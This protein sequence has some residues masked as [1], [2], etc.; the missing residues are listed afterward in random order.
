ML[1]ITEDAK[2]KVLEFISQETDP[3]MAL[4]VA[5]TGRQGTSFRY[6]FGLV[7]EAS[8]DDDDKMI[9]AG[10]FKVL[11]DKKSAE[12]LEGATFEWVE[13]VDGAGFSVNNPNSAWKDPVAAKVAEVIEQKINPSIASH[14]GHVT[15]LDVREQV[16]YVQLG[17]GCQGCGMAD[18]T[19]KE[20]IETAIKEAVPEIRGVVDSTDHAGGTNPYYSSPGGSCGG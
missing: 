18:V 1:T 3:D 10:E 12:Y 13:N 8:R 2:A 16:A 15:L 5:V 11:I 19:L 20:G 17:G 4:R 7:P 6:E 9:D 14:G